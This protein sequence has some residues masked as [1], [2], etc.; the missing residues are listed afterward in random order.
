MTVTV[1]DGVF[2]FGSGQNQQAPSHST[3]GGAGFANDATAKAIPGS[4]YRA[5]GKVWRY[6]QFDNG[7][8]NVAAAAGATAHWKTL[9]PASGSF[10]VTTDYSP[11]AIGKNLVAGILGCVVTD[12][13]YTWIQVGGVVTAL[14][15]FTSLSGD[16]VAAA[17][18]G[19]KCTYSTVDTK[20]RL[21][22]AATNPSAV[23]F[24]V[25]IATANYTAGTGSVLLQNLEW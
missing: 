20:L 5:H 17:V 21:I 2:T 13:Y 23:V 19:C 22:E 12:Q 1:T 11:D 3:F 8:G 24:G 15:D 18:A 4:L 14:V 7:T 9:A 10:V 6:V 25:L 16:P